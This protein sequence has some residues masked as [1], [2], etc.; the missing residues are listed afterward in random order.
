MMGF[1]RLLIFVAVCF[2]E[3]F[4]QTLSKHGGMEAVELEI[5]DCLSI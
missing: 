5:V 2:Y 1:I 4:L 3:K